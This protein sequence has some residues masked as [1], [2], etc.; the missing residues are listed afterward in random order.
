[1]TAAHTFRR[2]RTGA[3]AHASYV[4]Y[5]AWHVYIHTSRA[6]RQNKQAAAKY[7]VES[8]VLCAPGRR[9]YHME[10]VNARCSRAC[11]AGATRERE[12][13]TRSALVN[14]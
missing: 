3:L 8:H 5:D 13:E 12:R 11:P 7:A 10:I 1:M 14:P 9:H 6:R 4:V 2:A